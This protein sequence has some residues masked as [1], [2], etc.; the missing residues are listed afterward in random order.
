MS[1]TCDVE[2][3]GATDSTSKEMDTPLRRYVLEPDKQPEE[4]PAMAGPAAPVIVVEGP[5]LFTDK[6]IVLILITLIAIFCIGVVIH[7][8]R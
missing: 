5:S 4:V 7:A 6:Q 1:D 2:L 3:P 8:S